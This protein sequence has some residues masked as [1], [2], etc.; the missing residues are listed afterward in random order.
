MRERR[1]S[2]R[3][4]VNCSRGFHSGAQQS[5]AQQHWGIQK[6]E[7]G[8]SSWLHKRGEGRARAVQKIKHENLQT[9]YFFFA[10]FDNLQRKPLKLK[11][12]C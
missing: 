2:C 8:S 1:R 3:Q 12:T 10:F 5:A 4:G 7:I 6:L 11:N 9:N